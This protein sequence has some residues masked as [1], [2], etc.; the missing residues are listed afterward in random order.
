[1]TPE[2]KKK[3]EMMGSIGALIHT[4]SG[5]EFACSSGHVSKGMYCKKQQVYAP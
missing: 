5:V 4:L 1:M 2:E 3:M